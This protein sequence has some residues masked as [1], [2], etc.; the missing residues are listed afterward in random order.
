[1]EQVRAAGVHA[2]L[3]I[4]HSQPTRECG[5]Y[6]TKAILRDAE[7]HRQGEVDVASGLFSIA[8]FETWSGV[9][10]VRGSLSSH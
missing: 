9:S 1:V 8:E 3:D 7:R 6:N 5:I 10:N 4:L 2:L